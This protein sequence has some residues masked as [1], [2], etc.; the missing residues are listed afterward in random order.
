MEMKSITLIIATFICLNAMAQDNINPHYP[1][2][3]TYEVNNYSPNYVET[4]ANGVIQQSGYIVDGVLEGEWKEF[5]SSGNLT[6][7]A[8]YSSGKKHGDWKLYDSQGNLHYHII[9]DNGKKIAAKD[10]AALSSLATN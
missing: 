8:N 2:C 6:A 1:N 7:V 9:Y 5:D 4:H 10:Q 3:E